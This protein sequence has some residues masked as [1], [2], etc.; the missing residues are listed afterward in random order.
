MKQA[1]ESEFDVFLSYA[2]LDDK[3]VRPDQT[4]WVSLLRKALDVRLAQLIGQR[5]QIWMTQD[6][7]LGQHF[8]P[9][10]ER[11]LRKSR[12]LVTVVSPAYVHS[13]HCLKEMRYFLEAVGE[14][15]PGSPGSIRIFKVVKDPIPFAELPDPLNK[16]IGY[17]FFQ[18][19]HDTG[20]IR[21]YEPE[22][23]SST[24]DRFWL[25]LDD[26]A[27]AVAHAL[28]TIREANNVTSSAEAGIRSTT[29]ADH[30]PLEVIERGGARRAV[31]VF[32]CHSSA[33]KPGVRDLFRRLV[34]DGC[35]PWLDDE[36]LLPGQRWAEEI[37]RAVRNSDVVVVCM[38]PGA[39]AKRGYL[40][41]EIA[42]ALDIALE[43]PEGSIFLIPA[44]L[45]ECDVPERLRE[46][47]WVN[48]YEESGY[49]RLLKAIRAKATRLSIESAG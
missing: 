48:L 21:S 16:V 39:T 26:L 9:G 43:E 28:R 10:L 8:G 23:R 4:G 12:T 38:S 20:R 7:F 11:A 17:E 35:E 37:P 40:Q 13:E 15:L 47:Q 6:V 14:E 3:P 32:L 30:P 27:Q 29:A 44:R 41:K 33:D 24:G 49:A 34:Q 22:G 5:A 1:E 46:Y 45:E 31:R 19:D 36:K 2:G 42:F 18:T 25:L